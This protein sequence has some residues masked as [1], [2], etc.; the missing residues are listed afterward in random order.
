MSSSED[1]K[2]GKISIE[3]FNGCVG[4]CPGCSLSQEERESVLPVMSLGAFNDVCKK[5]AAHGEKA[6]YS[7]LVEILYGDFLALPLST[8][9]E[10]YDSMKRH[11]VAIGFTG[12]F[13]TKNH[14]EHYKKALKFIID[15]GY[16]E[17]GIMNITVDPFRLMNESYYKHNLQMVCSQKKE[18]K[19]FH[20]QILLSTTLITKL[21]PEKLISCVE[22]AVG[23]GFNIALIATPPSNRVRVSRYQYDFM[24]AAGYMR[25][26][27]A[28]RDYLERFLTLELSRFES[29]GI[30]GVCNNEHYFDSTIFTHLY[31]SRNG[32]VSPVIETV[33]GDV[34]LDGERGADKSIGNALNSL[35]FNDVL[36][37]KNKQRLVRRN[38]LKMSSSK[39]GCD[40]CEFYY[41]CLNKG[42]GLARDAYKEWDNRQG[43][44]FGVR[45]VRIS[46]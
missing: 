26:F 36:G 16:S 25:E 4:S 29:T 22:D 5:V 32:D 33:F 23:P 44:C 39:F 18:F 31:I 7:Y 11:G 3:V 37:T 9:K 43:S 14:E 27:Y 35:T 1:Y 6:G 8:Q 41:Q 28:S 10:Y 19:S 46:V 21:S 15:S 2:E 17:T 40:D 34:F 24:K 30:E 42:V 20:I 12:N 13:V 45:D 38:A